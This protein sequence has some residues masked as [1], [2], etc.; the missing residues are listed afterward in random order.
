ML[1]TDDS[2]AETI[3]TGHMDR[4]VRVAIEAGVPPITA[5]QMATINTAEHFGVAR[6]MGSIAPGRSADILLV[7]DL[8]DFHARTVIARGSAGSPGW[9]SPRANPALPISGLGDEQR[10]NSPQAH[11]Q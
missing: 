6:E 5:I 9:K 10:Q 8:K 3:Y 2:H 1:C 4:V 7:D 11:H